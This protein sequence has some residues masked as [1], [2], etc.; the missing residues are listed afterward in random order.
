MILKLS[1]ELK[2]KFLDEKN[3]K[4]DM[5]Q[6][7][8]EIK[9]LGGTTHNI[10]SIRWI[11][12]ILYLHDDPELFEECKEWIRLIR[13]SVYFKTSSF[14]TAKLTVGPFEGLFPTQCIGESKEVHFLTDSYHSGKGHWKDWFIQGDL[15]ASQ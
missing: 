11:E 14:T 6:E 1:P 5:R 9:G 3:L 10:P 15:Y 4:I 7:F 13:D 12:V 8:H 2:M